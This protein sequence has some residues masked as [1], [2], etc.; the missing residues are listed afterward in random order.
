MVGGS[1]FDEVL[2]LLLAQKGP[3]PLCHRPHQ[4]QLLLA[5]AQTHGLDPAGGHVGIRARRVRAE[6]GRGPSASGG[7]RGRAPR[8][9]L[10]SLPGHWAPGWPPRGCHCPTHCRRPRPCSGR[11]ARDSESR[12]CCPAPPSPR[13]PA[14]A[15]ASR[16]EETATGAETW[17]PQAGPG[18]AGGREAGSRDVDGVA[19]WAP[20]P[21]T[22][23]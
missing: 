14:R 8:H 2:C 4:A 16:L 17:G 22:P 19:A 7:R 21:E 10:T 18:D 23:G 12:G 15:G 9:S 1:L 3:W 5:V 20:A 11:S 13:R 6:G